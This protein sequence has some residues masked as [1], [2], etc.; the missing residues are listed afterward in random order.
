MAS[1]SNDQLTLL[2]SRKQNAG[3]LPI[4]LLPFPLNVLIATVFIF[5]CSS[6]G[7]AGLQYIVKRDAVH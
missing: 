1:T 7:K 2:C 3:C 5:N 6:F 4:V